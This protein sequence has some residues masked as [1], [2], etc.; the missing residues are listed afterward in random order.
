MK[1]FF[2]QL[3]YIVM[4]GV[5]PATGV[6][7]ICLI[8]SGCCKSGE[9]DKPTNGIVTSKELI[10]DGYYFNILTF[11][12]HTYIAYNRSML[13]AQSCSCFTTNK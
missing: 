8:A 11:E 2:K 5:I 9:H 4:G 13:H 12:G 7:V 10:V 6:L 1:D 3:F